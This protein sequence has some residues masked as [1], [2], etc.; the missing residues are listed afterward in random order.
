M[1]IGTFENNLGEKNRIALPKKF[2][3]ELG[4][5]VIVTK[6]YDDCL[7]IVDMKRWEKLLDSFKDIPFVN[8]DIRDTRRFL[9]GSAT[10]VQLDKQ[11]R[12]V[13]PENLKSYAK[14]LKTGVFLGLVDWVEIWDKEI[15]ADKE[16]NI[17]TNSNKIAEKV[18]EIIT[19]K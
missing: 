5:K 14:I 11:G 12:F 1:L 19:R 13:L 15:W 17:N 10:E 8:S 18:S 4:D 9:L 3:D 2:V 6:G 7:I 16:L